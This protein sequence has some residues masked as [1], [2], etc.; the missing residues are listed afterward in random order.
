MK[1]PLSALDH[2]PWPIPKRPWSYF[3]EWRD[4]VFLHYRVDAAFIKRTLPAGLE[5]DQFDGSAWVSLVAFDMINVRPRWTP[6]VPLISNFHEVNLRTYVRNGAMPGVYFFRIH[7]AKAISVFLARTLSILPYEKA[8]LHRSTT[9]DGSHEFAADTTDGTWSLRYRVAP[10]ISRPSSLDAWL[11]ERYCLYQ[12]WREQ[13]QRYQVHHV[14]WPL[15]ECRIEN[16][17][18]IMPFNG[19]TFDT[20]EAA[21][22][23]PGVKVLSWDR[24]AVK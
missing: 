14:P 8:E 20:F 15:H 5:P 13:L 4:L 24:E 19:L 7:A 11:T 22:Y 6:A 12:P 2:R 23:S 21:H 16:A 18:R 3:Q 9:E 1:E 17:P 10:P